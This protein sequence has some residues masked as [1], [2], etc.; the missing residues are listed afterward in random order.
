MADADDAGGFFV[1]GDLEIGVVEVE[2]DGAAAADGG[3]GA[4][5]IRIERRF[6][7]HG[8]FGAGGFDS[9]HQLFKAVL[10]RGRLRVIKLAKGFVVVLHWYWWLGGVC[11]D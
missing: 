8:D 5:D 9:V 10:R 2:F 1:A 6:F 3:F 11:S 7:V 4:G